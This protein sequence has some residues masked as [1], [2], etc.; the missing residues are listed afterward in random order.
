[1]TFKA[2]YRL[3]LTALLIA[4]SPSFSNAQLSPIIMKFGTSTLND[5]IHEWAKIFAAHVNNDSAGRIK[6]EVYPGNQLGTSPRMIEQTQLGSI[7]GVAGAPEF[8]SGVNPAFQVLGAPGLFE[9]LAHTNR[10]LQDPEFNKAYLE[11]GASK[12]LKGVG[13][14]I[15]GPTLFVSRKPITKLSDFKD[16]KTRVLSGRLQLAQVRKLGGSPVPMP[17]GEVLP[18]LQQGALDSVMSCIPVFVALRYSDVAKYIVETNHGL[19]AG[20]AMISKVWF[21]KLT[22]DL[23]E[24]IVKAGQKASNDVYQ[25]SVDDVNRGRD[26]WIKAGGTVTKLVPADQVKLMKDMA[27]VGANETQE[28]AQEKAMYD[29]L[30]KVVQRTK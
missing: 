6:V 26:A 29:L 23:Q 4:V 22:P 14:L 28:T 2:T 5:S 17:L 12:G 30:K 7:Q 27:E 13:L 20:A 9:D 1:M 15:S 16:L 10:V 11:L 19:I 21:D 3:L 18:A 8:L 24:V 25:F